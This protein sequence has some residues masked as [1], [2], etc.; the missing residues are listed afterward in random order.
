MGGV[1]PVPAVLDRVGADVV[2]LNP[3]QRCALHI[4]RGLANLSLGHV[5]AARGDLER[6][7]ATA[8][9]H[10]LADQE[11]KARHN[12]AC[13]AFVDGDLTRALV[14][15]RQADAMDV[16]VSRDRARL[17]QAEVLLEAGLVDGA[18]A[19]LAQALTLRPQRRSPSRGG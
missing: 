18:R 14:L 13:L 3:S 17:D 5:A 1:G 19:A 15:M 2:E 11:F 7:V 8:A 10:G 4:N 6:A 12:L 16:A 9:E